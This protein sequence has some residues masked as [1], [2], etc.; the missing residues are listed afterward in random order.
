M[1][2]YLRKPTIIAAFAALALAFPANSTMAAPQQVQVAQAVYVESGTYIGR[3]GDER[4]SVSVVYGEG[5][6]RLTRND[7]GNTTLFEPVRGN[8]FRNDNG[9]V[10]KVRNPTSFV[11]SG[12][13]GNRK[14]SFRKQ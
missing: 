2:P 6:I 7:N 14:I 10:I 4:F 3:Q 13:N 12:A 11:F 9:A 8:N 1:K 5:R